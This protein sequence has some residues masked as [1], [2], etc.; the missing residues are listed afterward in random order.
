MGIVLLLRSLINDIREVLTAYCIMDFGSEFERNQGFPFRSFQPFQVKFQVFYSSTLGNQRLTSD[1][2][3]AGLNKAIMRYF[4]DHIEAIKA[5]IASSEHYDS[6]WIE[7]L[8]PEIV[9]WVV[10]NTNPIRLWGNAMAHYSTVTTIANTARTYMQTLD[11]VGHGHVLCSD[12][13]STPS[14]LFV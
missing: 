2:F 9:A 7:I 4:V 10:D 5:A 8:T 11:G 12:T 13:L 6:S 14:S 1:Q 3:A